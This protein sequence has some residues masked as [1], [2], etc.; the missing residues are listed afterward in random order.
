M[1]LPPMY[2]TKD[3]LP[4]FQNFMGIPYEGDGVPSYRSARDF[5]NAPADEAWVYACTRRLF[6]SAQSVP[7]RVYV[8]RGKERVLA[9]DAKGRY[10]ARDLQHLL[11]NINPVSMNGADF[12]GYTAAGMF[13]ISGG[14]YW[15]KVRGIRGGP[16]QELY[17]LPP[18]D[19][20][21]EKDPA[22]YGAVRAY[23]YQANGT[24]SREE[25][26]PRDMLRFRAFN[27]G[28]PVEFLSPLGAARNQ[29]ATNRL[30][31]QQMAST[32]ANW[33][34]PP[35]YWEVGADTQEQDKGLIRR[36][37]R[38]LR[39]PRNAGKSAIMPNGVKYQNIA[40]N[41]KDAEWLSAQKVSRLGVCAVTGVPLLLAGDDEST[42]PYAYAREIWRMFWQGTMI[43]DLDQ[44][45][46]T[47]NG[48]LVPDFTTRGDIEVA[49]DYS[50]IEALQV[51]LEDRKRVAIEE[52][53]AQVLTPDEYRADLLQK[54]PLPKDAFPEPV[55]P[56]PGSDTSGGEAPEPDGKAL[57]DAIRPL[58]DIYTQ[59]AVAKWLADPSGQLDAASILG[60][61]VSD[62]QR[63]LIE[64]GLK[65][66]YSSR[67]IADGVAAEGYPGLHAKEAEPANPPGV[68]IYNEGAMPV[69]VHMDPV[70]DAIK[71]LDARVAAIPAPDNSALEAKV[72]RLAAVLSQPV[73]RTPVRNEKGL[74][75][76]VVETRG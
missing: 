7:L 71:A 60:R 61:A 11:D 49:F 26:K 57:A 4:A 36:A 41:P 29:I 50:Q 72:D 1:T 74:V 3:M 68:T 2:A 39:G 19:V 58:K 9:E 21:P 54:G 34:I 24:T 43:P 28:D 12:R 14:A 70:T 37:L 6:V 64:K 51:P 10:D 55:A 32:I 25:I 35:G 31:T 46:D 73:T 76:R 45:A 53:R 15:R 8:K 33:S 38:A 27:F 47:I 75:E 30:A 62:S 16:P 56:S 42:G 22:I 63:Q 69:T 67:Q 44:I 48:W 59:P 52:V 23:V 66:R 40:L 18:N 5:A 20:A 65:R 17:F 13:G